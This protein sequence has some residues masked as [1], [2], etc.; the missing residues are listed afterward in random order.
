MDNE[1]AAPADEPPPDT[2]G[3]PSSFSDEIADEICRRMAEG[4][5][6]RQICRD[7]GMPARST[8]TNWCEADPE[9][10]GARFQLAYDA[11]VATWSEEIIDIADDATNDW[12]ER[13]NK[14]GSKY[15]AIDKEHIT[16]SA[17]RVK[18]RQ[19]L[20]SKLNSKRFGDKLAV[21]DADGGVLRVKIEY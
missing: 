5:T 17:L 19:W 3:R 8:L 11:L 21:T 18:T 16:R 20:L 14:D 2:G 13:E 7:E 9:G 6:P 4:E 1:I 15:M 10:F 12:V